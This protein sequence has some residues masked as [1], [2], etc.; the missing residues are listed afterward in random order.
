MCMLKGIK[1]KEREFAAHIKIKKKK[2]KRF[3]QHKD[4]LFSFF[5]GGGGVR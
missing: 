2:D 5:W 1:S 3:G 4:F